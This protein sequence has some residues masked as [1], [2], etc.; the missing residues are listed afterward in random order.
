M[1]NPNH[2]TVHDLKAT[3]R[4]DMLIVRVTLDR[5]GVREAYTAKRAL[6]QYPEDIRL[7]LSSALDELSTR[8]NEAFGNKL[9]GYATNPRTKVREF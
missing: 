2:M 4:D 1:Y 8:L 6:G 9:T 5:N 7:E 3:V